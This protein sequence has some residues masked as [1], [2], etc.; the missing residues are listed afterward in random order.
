MDRGGAGL[1]ARQIIGWYATVVAIIAACLLGWLWSNRD[2]RAPLIPPYPNVIGFSGTP[3]PFEAQTFGKAD[4]GFRTRDAPEVVS[5]F[6]T[7]MFREQGWEKRGSRHWYRN[8]ASYCYTVLIIQNDPAQA[9]VAPGMAS[10]VIRLRQA[11]IQ[12]KVLDAPPGCK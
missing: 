2:Y 3:S 11:H 7:T 6:Y 8:R 10:F 1:S 4:G 5:A 9:K 12:E